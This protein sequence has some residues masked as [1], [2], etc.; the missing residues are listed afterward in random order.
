VAVIAVAGIFVVAY[1]SAVLASRRAFGQ[2]VR[3]PREAAGYS[4]ALVKRDLVPSW[5]P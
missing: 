5:D 2:V 3:M 1:G 4:A